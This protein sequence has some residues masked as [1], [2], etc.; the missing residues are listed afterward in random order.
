MRSTLVHRWMLP[1]AL[2]LALAG[3]GKSTSPLSSHT[4][5]DQA[6]AD[7]VALQTGATLENAM[8]DMGGAVTVGAAPSAPAGASRGFSANAVMWD[9]TFTH[10]GI[11]F[12]AS[13]TFYN[14]L[15]VALD[16]Y[17]PTAV[18]LVWTSRVYG[19]AATVRDTLTLGR[20][21]STEI[22][23]IQPLQDTLLVNGSAL[24]TLMNHFRSLDGTRMRYFYW[25]SALSVHDVR[26]LKSTLSS[27]GWP[28][29][30]TLTFV[31]SADR[32]R[33][34][35]RADVEAHLN[36]TV[37][38]TFN[39]TSQPDVVVDGTWHYHWN[40]VTGAIVRA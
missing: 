20:T 38:V 11:T 32:L 31:V 3:C 26:A 35:D 6:T 23:G 15:G 37:V 9:T 29:S 25:N 12:E 8:L 18:R 16:A 19:S 4:N 5:I 39:G 1:A 40:L 34:N 24:D 27:G 33:S 28:L 10:G 14:A 2:V 13:R 22:R 21:A 30:G 17:G 7:D 36:A